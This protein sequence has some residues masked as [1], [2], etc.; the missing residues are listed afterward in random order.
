M[1]KGADFSEKILMEK[2]EDRIIRHGSVSRVFH[3]L[4]AACIL[5]LL[6]TGLL[7]VL[8]FKFEWVEPHW[9]A[10]IALT[11]AV[12]IHL[13]RSLSPKKLKSMWISVTDIRDFIESRGTVLGGKYSLEQKLMHHA[14]TLFSLISLI[15]GWLLLLKIDTP[16]WQRNPFIFQAETWGIIYVFHGLSTLI[17]V[18]SI[19]LHIYFSLRPEKSMYLRSMFKG[20]ITRDEFNKNHDPNRWDI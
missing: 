19:M 9:I 8:G 14:I 5:T 2:N 15:T 13:F 10:G 18:S 12:L 16:F 17:F 6:A 11:I 20:W 4:M 3:W 7:P 1:K